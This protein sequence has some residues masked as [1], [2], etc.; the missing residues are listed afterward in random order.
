MQPSPVEIQREVEALRD[1]RRRSTAQGGPGSLVLDPDL[2]IESSPTSPS[3]G[4]W[5]S[6]TSPGLTDGDSSSSSHEDSSSSE[7]SSADD[8]F[9]LFWVPARLHP[10][11][12]PTEFRAF[13]KEHA[14]NPPAEGAG[15]LSRSASAASGSSSGLGRRTSLLSRQYRPTESDGSEDEQVLPL[16]RNRS[17]IY[18]PG[19][20]LTI[21][22]LQKLD[23]LAE[24]ASESDDPTK[25]RNIL[26][27][28]LSL[29]V[30]PSAMDTMDN[31]PDPGEDADAPI[32]VPRP[33]QILRRAAR[34]KIRK[35]GLPG[36]GGGH[37]FG[38]STRRRAGGGRTAATAE[39][40]TSSDMSSSDHGEQLEPPKR[41]HLSS[42]EGP[43]DDHI[44]SPP[45]RPDSYSEEAS[46]IFD[47]YVQEME[48]D[49]SQTIVPSPTISPPSRVFVTSPPLPASIELPVSP[50]PQ[51]PL[52]P[53]QPVSDPIPILA[54]PTSRIIHQPKPQHAATLRPPTTQ[55]PARA[56][57]P[58][59][60]R[61]GEGSTISR[62]HSPGSETASLVSISPTPKKEKDKKSLFGFGRD[63]SVKKA[64]RER[65][66]EK[67]KEKEKEG[68]F[69]GS[70][71]GGK[72]KQDDSAT[73]A[74]AGRETAAAFGVS[75]SSKSNVSPI[76]PQLIA[77]DG[78]YA[79]YPIHVERAIY[80][81]SHIKLANPRRPLYE[82]VLISN[83]MFWYLGVINKTQSPGSPGSGQ[84]Q[85]G[86]SSADKEVKEREQHDVDEQH[87]AEKEKERLEKEKERD[88]EQQQRKE[89]PPKR[90]SLTK[91]TSTGAHGGR[92]AAEMPVRGP[93]YEMQHRVMQQEYSSLGSGSSPP[94]SP[95]SS[96]GP[97]RPGQPQNTD[98]NAPSRSRSATAT[99]PPTQ[100]PVLPN[101]KL[102][103]NMSAQAVM[104][105]GRKPRRSDP[106]HP[107]GEEEDMPLA[108][109]QQR[110]RR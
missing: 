110:Q 89:A 73:Q 72:K 99:A 100:P 105:N 19:P 20:Q 108:V 47:A 22:D 83:L 48:E 44:Q 53:L 21:N 38:Q 57:S 33:G 58:E 103:K 88:R 104:A 74:G 82:Q 40:R 75:K 30:A 49:E 26:R 41:G 65:E 85:H 66:E 12:A 23:Q 71:F 50:P 31:M 35:P 91:N 9:H 10:E 84:Q 14:R 29:N 2:P 59:A 60:S 68:G 64:E 61:S 25:L 39:Q 70:F 37:R 78:S 90:G 69:F 27:R 11:I 81:L 24:E 102:R 52:Q 80:R 3:A 18:N 79:R 76:S 106:T 101:G 107:T 34:T 16:R 109:W 45:L 4:Y 87:K 95:R 63:K 32:I 62:S 77:A 54:S 86:H 56:T 43:P 55:E 42:D 96:S 5:T 98:A 28:S 46:S 97:P 93:Q 17:S 7:R 1:I 15:G 92:R 51:S 36:D 67:K 6:G 8:P 94:M 13:L